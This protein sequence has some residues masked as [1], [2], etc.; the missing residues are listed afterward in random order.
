MKK[1]LILGY[2]TSGKGSAKLLIN[3]G[4]EVYFFDESVE[5]T[6]DFV[7]LAGRDCWDVVQDKDLIVI[8]PGVS[9]N[10]SIVEYAEKCGIEIIGEI[11][12]GYRHCKGDVIAV[13][14]T[15]G[16]TTTTLLIKRIL[17]MA[18]IDSKALG[19]IGESF[20]G[21][22]ADDDGQDKVLVLEVSSYQLESVKTFRPRFALCL[23][24]TPDHLQR[25]KTM[26]IYTAM[27]QRI[28]CN[29]TQSDY[30][31][32]NYDCDVTRNMGDTVRGQFYYYSL[33]H[34]VKGVYVADGEIYFFDQEKHRVCSVSDT[35]IESDYNLSNVLAA[36]TVAKLMNI[37]NE[38][39]V[40][41][42][43]TFEMPKYRRQYIGDI[44]GVKFFNDSKA[45][46]FDSTI[47]ACKAVNGS[48]A[49]IIGGYDKGISYQPF[50][51]ALPQNVGFIAVCG[52]NCD[53]I[54][55]FL[56]LVHSYHFV[57]CNQL[58]RAATL[59][60]ESGMDNVL[61]S[62]TTSSFDRYSGYEER[63]EH[64]DRIFKELLSEKGKKS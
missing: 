3:L 20:A 49:L 60:L 27:K 45:T 58:K 35:L 53:R 18:G 34:R 38:T 37:D 62:P 41:A 46:N 40:K 64:F 47:N 11:E 33:K 61:F 50:F 25:H 30:A 12:L 51:D 14:G 24:V 26:A 19:N 1:A 39:I 57:R 13:T 22:M 5:R 31:I 59:A 16:K 17:T 23:N 43:S 55:E 63:G 48:V 32:L 52:D 28:F 44:N 54:M 29:Q 8:S 4:Y 36:I 56:P 42:I 15:N 9:K 2:G 10:H 6:G 21:E 7:N